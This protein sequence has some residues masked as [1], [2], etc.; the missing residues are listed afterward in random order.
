MV[1]LFNSVPLARPDFSYLHTK[2]ILSS[3]TLYVL[4]S[5]LRIVHTGVVLFLI[6]FSFH[7]STDSFFAFSFAWTFPF[8]SLSVVCRISVNGH[9]LHARHVVRQ[10]RGHGRGH[11][12]NARKPLCADAS[13]QVEEHRVWHVMEA[14]HVAS[15]RLQAETFLWKVQNLKCTHTFIC[16]ST[17]HFKKILAKL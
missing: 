2:S 12:G 6:S 4:F 8:H 9:V 15:V 13:D 10:H 11:G 7:N 16:R 3:L 17:V 1:F 5:L 14:E